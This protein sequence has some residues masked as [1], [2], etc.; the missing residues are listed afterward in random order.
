MSSTLPPSITLQQRQGILLCRPARNRS[1]P[2][3][4]QETNEQ[5]SNHGDPQLRTSPTSLNFRIFR[6][7]SPRGQPASQST[8]ESRNVLP[9]VA[10][11]FFLS[12]DLLHVRFFTTSSLDR[13]WTRLS[14]ARPE[15]MQ[16]RT[17]PPAL[18]S[19]RRIRAS[20]SR[21]A[22]ASFSFSSCS[23]TC[24]LRARCGCGDAI[25]M[26][27]VGLQERV[28]LFMLRGSVTAHEGQRNGVGCTAQ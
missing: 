22:F 20:S 19:R 12:H 15:Q 13:R 10:A 6:A 9:M 23:E 2:H 3:M 26:Q 16:Q 17:T 24:G 14:C 1:R 21:L 8:P 28:R 4:C 5:G 25:P 7:T 11:F 27:R 18:L